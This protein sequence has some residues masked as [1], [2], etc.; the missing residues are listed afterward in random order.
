MQVRITYPSNFKQQKAF[1]FL[2]KKHILRNLINNVPEN[3][4]NIPEQCLLQ[5]AVVY[6]AYLRHIY[7]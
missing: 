6:E 1:F 3:Q 7:M 2:V 5:S 4:N